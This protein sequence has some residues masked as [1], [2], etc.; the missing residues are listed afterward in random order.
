MITTEHVRRLLASDTPGAALVIVAGRAKVSATPAEE[1]G[2]VVATREDLLKGRNAPP[3]EA[4]LE[5][6]ARSLNTAVA[7]Q[8][9]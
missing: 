6:L 1:G 9:G 4:R 7:D 8:G 2:L 5:A 3:D